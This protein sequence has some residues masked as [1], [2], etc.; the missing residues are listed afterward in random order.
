MKNEMVHFLEALNKEADGKLW[1]KPTEKYVQK[2][3]LNAHVLKYYIEGDMAGVIAFYANDFKER[4]AFLSF[5]GVNQKYRG[6]GIGKILIIS[7]L[8]LLK[9][10]DFKSYSLE[11]LKENSAA[12]KTYRSLGFEVVSVNNS[13]NLMTLKL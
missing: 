9:A 4:K 7:S 1:E 6:K 11:V 12:I 2:L 5:V 8:N 3:L 13:H 10:K